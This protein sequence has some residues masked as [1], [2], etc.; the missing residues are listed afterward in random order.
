MIK[1]RAVVDDIV[2]NDK[3]QRVWLAGVRV[4]VSSSPSLHAVV[5]GLTTGFG[6]FARVSV[7]KE[8][9]T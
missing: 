8:K 6:K 2:D 3:G 7:P 1:A 9:L 5:Y 4:G